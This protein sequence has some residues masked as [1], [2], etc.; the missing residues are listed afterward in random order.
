MNNKDLYNLLSKTDLTDIV[1]PDFSLPQHKRKKYVR[2]S[3]NKIM[4]YE[5]SNFQYTEK[6]FKPKK[7]LTFARLAVLLITSVTMMSL[8]VVMLFNFTAV[9]AFVKNLFYI[10]GIGITDNENLISAVLDEPTL[11]KV[12]GREYMLEFATKVKREDGRC[13]I[14]LYFS[15]DYFIRESYITPM[16]AIINGKEY[17]FTLGN[18]SY[19]SEAVFIMSNY[20]FPDVNEFELKL[21]NTTTQIVMSEL[22]DEEKKPNL[23]NEINGIKLVAYKYRNNNALFGIDVIN[24]NKKDDR[25]N[26]MT[27][28]HNLN[29]YDYDGNIL[30]P[31][32]YSGGAYHPESKDYGLGYS[33]VT[34]KNNE[35]KNI[36]KVSAD[37]INIA[38]HY[39]RNR[40][41]PLKII[42]P[43]PEDGETI[44]TDIKIPVGGLLY[45][46]TEVRR[47]GDTIYFEDNRN[48]GHDVEKNL[49]VYI[50]SVT[51]SIFVE[52]KIMYLDNKEITIF[53]P[54]DKFI[55]ME[56]NGFIIHYNGNFVI[57]FD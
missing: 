31:K 43:I 14:L 53:N 2:K 5:K 32:G 19:G 18:V 13:E 48:M 20:D 35:N 16:S 37:G 1:P 41:E 34:F 10:P 54:D 11:I 15:A 46:M 25:F 50:Q 30:N 51:I 21:H 7:Q 22:S 38:Y 39:D 49:E 33:V 24:N 29:V 45:E 56:L 42:V 8:M 40:V 44:H 12:N 55:E 9:V 52:N 27:V 57:N 3:M 28:Y 4:E 47:D 17:E 36:A 23:S 6:A 26:A